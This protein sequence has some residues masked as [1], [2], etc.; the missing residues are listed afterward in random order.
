MT[1]DGANGDAT[2]GDGVYSAKVKASDA[3][4]YYFLA[5]S[6]E[7]ALTYP[8]RASYDFLEVK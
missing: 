7:A 6:E 5:E 2:A 8:E 3:I 1:D 4:Q